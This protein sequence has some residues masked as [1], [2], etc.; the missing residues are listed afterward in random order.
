MS[1]KT[2]QSLLL[3]IRWQK[4]TPGDWVSTRMK[5]SGGRWGRRG[6]FPRILMCRC[7]V[8]Q[9]LRLARVRTSNKGCFAPCLNQRV[10]LRGVE[11]T[12]WIRV[13]LLAA[14][15]GR[16]GKQYPCS[17]GF[18]QQNRCHVSA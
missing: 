1:T 2:P 13:T 14:S 5:G 10:L 4:A 9:S 18:I 3:L 12:K 15:V 17:K 8:D 6:R 16:R 11:T 7:N